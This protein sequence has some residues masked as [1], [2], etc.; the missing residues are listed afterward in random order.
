MPGERDAVEKHFGIGSNEWFEQ[1]IAGDHCPKGR[2]AG[3]QPFGTRDHVWLI[4][5]SFATE[6][7]TKTTE[8]T[9]HLV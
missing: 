8:G 5:E 4:T 6:H 7:V 3:R 2:V 9:D 1:S